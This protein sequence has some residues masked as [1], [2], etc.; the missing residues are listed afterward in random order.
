MAKHPTKID[1]LRYVLAVNAPETKDSEFT[2]KNYQTLINNELVAN[3]GNFVNRV[4]V[5][6]NK[7][8]DG[9]IPAIDLTKK[10]NNGI[11]QGEQVLVDEIFEELADKVQNY[12]SLIEQFKFRDALAQLMDISAY[13]NSFLQFNEPWKLV[14]T[15]AEKVKTIMAVALNITATLSALCEPYLPITSKKIKQILNDEDLTFDFEN[16]KQCISH[17]TKEG[18]KINKASILFEKIEDEFVEQELAALKANIPNN[19]SE[20]KAANLKPEVVYDDFAKLDFRVGTITAAEKVAKAD[21]LLKLEVDMGFETRTVVSG[22][23]E[24]FKAA[25]I[26]GQQVTVV[27]NLAP[28]KLRGT[29]S[30]GM[31]LMAEDADGKLV[32]QAPAEKVA[33]GSTVN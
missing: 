8:Y 5:L 15:D 27:A 6:T 26:I 4:L 3:F 13:G 31:I 1:E 16:I 11:T 32:F 30:Q 21:K 28:R 19:E 10:I 23:A 22:I 24:H 7:Y 33:N 9:E 17:L 14:K 20:A 18:Q 2:W 29:M 25:D 12:V